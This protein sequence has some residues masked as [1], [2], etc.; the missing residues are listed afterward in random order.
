MLAEQPTTDPSG[1]LEL[2]IA[3]PVLALDLVSLK[4]VQTKAVN[5]SDWG[6]KLVGEGLSVLTKNIALKLDDADEFQKGKITSHKSG[7]V[8]V[9]FSPE[10]HQAREKRSEPRFPVTVAAKVQD[11]GRSFELCCIVTDASRSGCRI[12]GEGIGHLPDDLL[13]YMDGFDKP[14]RGQVAWKTD[15]KA[16]L[17]LTWNGAKILG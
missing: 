13:V 3:I 10:E 16:G 9:V 7:Y 8:T 12:E 11:L 4:C 15:T 2:E 6:C 1:E 14:V 5:F 17:R